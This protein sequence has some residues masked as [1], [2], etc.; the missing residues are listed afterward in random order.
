MNQ[1]MVSKMQ[2]FKAMLLKMAPICDLPATALVFEMANK[3]DKDETDLDAFVWAGK[4]MGE[5]HP[6]IDPLLWSAAMVVANNPEFD[7]RGYQR[8]E[9][10]AQAETAAVVEPKPVQYD[11]VVNP[12]KDQPLVAKASL[13]VVEPRI[14]KNKIPTPIT[15]EDLARMVKLQAL[16]VAELNRTGLSKR[17]LAQRIEASG[18]KFGESTLG[19]ISFGRFTLMDKRVGR[20]SLLCGR[21]TAA[22]VIALLENNPPVEG[23]EKKTTVSEEVKQSAPKVLTLENTTESITPAR[24]ESESPNQFQR[25]LVA[26]NRVAKA[27]RKNRHPM[28]LADLAAKVG[29]ETSVVAPLLNSLLE[30]KRVQRLEDGFWWSS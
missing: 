14:P 19:Q 28:K 29:W 2:V 11:V 21:E 16:L 3:L 23:G 20:P 18:V 9:L 22:K 12:F 30:Q 1:E 15:E 4:R 5:V 24:H 17:A 26:E 13:P 27:L 25:R 7:D 10:V 6:G 8:V